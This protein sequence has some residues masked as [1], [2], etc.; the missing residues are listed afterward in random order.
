[1]GVFLG[2]MGRGAPFSAIPVFPH[3]K[4]CHGNVLIQRR[5]RHSKT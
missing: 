2:W 5:E 1:M 3:R 4:F